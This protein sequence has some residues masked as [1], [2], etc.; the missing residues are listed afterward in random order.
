MHSV[1]ALA[2]HQA[3]YLIWLPCS[4]VTDL[5]CTAAGDPHF[6]VA[7]AALDAVQ[8]CLHHHSE[9]VEMSL[10]RLLPLLSQRI[11]DPKEAIRSAAVG[12]G[13][14][15]ATSSTSCLWYHEP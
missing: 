5:S 10:D 6:K 3:S 12:Y 4:P 14:V 9:L 7:H 13:H 15:Y 11:T 1:S 2:L 8:A